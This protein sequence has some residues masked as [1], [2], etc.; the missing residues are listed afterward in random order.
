MKKIILSIILIFMAAMLFGQDISLPEPKAKLGIDLLEAIN[1]RK[2]ARNFVK[3]DAAPEDLSTILWAANGLKK[4]ADAVTS[5]SKANRTIPI[6]GDVDYINV[7]LFNDK[8]AYAYDPVNNQLKLIAN[9]DLR[10]SLTPE[11]IKTSAFIILF[12]YDNSKVPAFLKGNAAMVSQIVDGS[13]SYGAQNAALAAG[14]MK[15]DSIIMYNIKPKDIA[16]VLKLGKDEQPLFIMQ[17]GF[18]Q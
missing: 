8:G 16:S 5:A 17:V 10:S 18:H 4:G 11:V 7:Y 14:A 9:G 3:H 1:G 6:S 13:A 12:T 15:M 2:A